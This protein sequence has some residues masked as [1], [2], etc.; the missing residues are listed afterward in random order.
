M[1]LPL[2]PQ[3]TSICGIIPT[4]Y[5]LNSVRRSQT[6]KRARQSPPNWVGKKKR[7]GG[8]QD[9]YPWERAVKE[10]RFPHPEKYPQRQGYQDRGGV[11]EPHRHAQQ[12]VCRGQNGERP[13]QKVG[14]MALSSPA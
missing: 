7:W 5:L 12:P 3:N 14:A 11:L 8:G 9:L 10:E 4:E 2:P 6:S 13:A 1:P